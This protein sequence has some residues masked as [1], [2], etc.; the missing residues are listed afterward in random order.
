MAFVF[1]WF[2]REKLIHSVGMADVTQILSAIEAGDKHAA[3]ELLPLV[4]DELRKL[5]A[6]RL[7]DEKPGQTLQPTDLVHEA[8]LRLVGGE[9][10]QGWDGRGHFFAAAAEA[11]RRILVEAARRK[12][13]AKRGGNFLRLD[14]EPVSLADDGREADLLALDDAVRTRAARSPRPPISSN[15]GISPVSH[16]RAAGPSGSVGGP[17]TGCGPSPGRGCTS[18][19][20][21]KSSRFFQNPRATGDGFSHWGRVEPPRTEVLP[22]QTGIRKPTT[23]S[24]KQ[25]RSPR[26][27][28][29]AGSS[30][31]LVPRTSP[32]APGWRL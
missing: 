1:R 15:C 25:S 7:A 20:P 16:R 9:H 21:T 6:A 24:Y 22:C 17:P 12:A 18:A 2:C 11:M 10:P 3:A 28:S 30:T 29:A 14:V 32:C 4:Y 8:Y 13:T 23:S 19:S 27:R 5:A 31:P 26:P